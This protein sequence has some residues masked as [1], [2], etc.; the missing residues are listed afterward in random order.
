MLVLLAN[1]P[2][3]TTIYACQA[4]W[5]VCLFVRQRALLYITWAVTHPSTDWTQRCLA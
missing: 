5:G 2:C 3:E 1:T 4:L